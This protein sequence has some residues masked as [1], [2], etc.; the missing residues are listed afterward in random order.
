VRTGEGT[1]YIEDDSLYVLNQIT[2]MIGVEYQIGQ[3]T[4]PGYGFGQYLQNSFSV[5]GDVASLNIGGAVDK[6]AGGVGDYAK[7]Q[8]PSIKTVGTNG[9]VNNLFGVITIQSEF[10]LLVNEDITRKGRP[11]CAIRTINTLS[12]FIQVDKADI[13]I[14]TAEGEQEEIRSYMEGG[15]YY[16]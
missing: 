12:G 3:I 9:G 1:L 11:L 8:I 10:K 15:F 7:S 13:D 16:E 6:I 14:A 4:K 5:L 2:S